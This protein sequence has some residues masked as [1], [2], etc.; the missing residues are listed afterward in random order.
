MSQSNEFGAAIEEYY[1]DF[2]SS[3]M[4][5]YLVCV[6]STDLLTEIEK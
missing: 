6:L 4:D 1:I 5:Q 2:I 3:T